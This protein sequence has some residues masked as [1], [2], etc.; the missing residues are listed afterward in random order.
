MEEETIRGDKIREKRLYL[1]VLEC[2]ANHVILVAS[3][4]GKTACQNVDLTRVFITGKTRLRR[5][6]ALVCIKARLCLRGRYK[7]RRQIGAG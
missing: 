7:A 4:T 1:A 5:V 2:D 3:V 6:K